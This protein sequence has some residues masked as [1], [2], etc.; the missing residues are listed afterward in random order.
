[1]V[2]KRYEVTVDRSVF[3]D[4]EMTVDTFDALEEIQE[5]YKRGNFSVWDMEIWDRHLK[6]K[7]DPY[8]T[9]MIY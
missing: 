2:K 8:S 3:G 9:M 4:L 5:F 7:I 6:Q 1:M